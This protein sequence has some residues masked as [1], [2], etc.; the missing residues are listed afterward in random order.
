MNSS[1]TSDLASGR[2]QHLEQ[3]ATVAL[4]VGRILMETGARSSVVK[5]GMRKIATG[6]AATSSHSRIGYASIS[7]TVSQGQTTIT[8]MLGVEQHRVD[9]RLNHA[10]R[11]LCTEAE[12]GGMSP[13]DISTAIDSLTEK[14]RHH[15]RLVI[16]VGAGVA[17]AAFGRL[18]GTDWAS[19]APIFA[20]STIAQVVRMALVARETNVFVLIA[21]VAFLA[22]A[23]A[24]LGAIWAGSETLGIAMTAAVLLLVP[25]V[26]SMNAQTDIMEGFPT[27]GSARFVTVAMIL[28]FITVGMGAARM[29]VAPGLDSLLAPPASVVHQAVFGGLAAA[30]FGLM[31]NFGFVTLIW[32]TIAGG[33]AL[34]V[35]TVGLELDWSL[36]AASFIA[37]M[38]VALSVEL[39]GARLLRVP[40][41]GQT[42]A[43]AGCIPMVPG[44]AAAQCITGLFEIST[45]DPVEAQIALVGSASAGLEVLFTL[46]AIGAGLTI[47]WSLAPR[48][49]F[50]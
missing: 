9:M 23:I 1:E 36:E 18:L 34:A 20:A 40:H 33:I 4:A 45:L 13:Q 21:I 8:R 49:E 48:R 28:I 11:D 35:R 22:S 29:I 7:L 16:A 46:G 32:A 17:C 14:T 44:G 26:P 2:Q 5:T 50:P 41:A 42:L 27:L 31:F 3:T 43:L 38:A 15:H 37:A 19:V 6:L 39:L 30:G 10:V 12:R 25:G 24:G 47:V